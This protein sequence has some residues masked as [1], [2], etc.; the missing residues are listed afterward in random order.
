MAPDCVDRREAAAQ[1]QHEFDS[2][3]DD[4]RPSPQP[5]SGDGVVGRFLL[6]GKRDLSAKRLRD[7][8]AMRLYG[9]DLTRPQPQACQRLRRDGGEEKPC[10]PLHRVRFHLA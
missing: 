2:R 5:H 7:I 4:G 8:V 3:L 10:H 6:I 9:R 1:G